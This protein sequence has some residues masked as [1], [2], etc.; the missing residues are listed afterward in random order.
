V[1]SNAR[2]AIGIRLLM[3]IAVIG[4]GSCWIAA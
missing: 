4:F 1:P 2:Q 3:T